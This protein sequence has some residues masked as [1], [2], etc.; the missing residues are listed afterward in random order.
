MKHDNHFIVVVVV[1]KKEKNSL[2]LGL[3]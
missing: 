3:T 1:G 2:G